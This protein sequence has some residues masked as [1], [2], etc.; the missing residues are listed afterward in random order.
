MNLFL[1]TDENTKEVIKEDT[2]E[3]TSIFNNFDDNDEYVT[4]YVHI[5][6]DN[7]NIEMIASKYN[8]DTDLIKEY[9]DINEIT[10]GSKLIIPQIINETI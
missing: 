10:L 1:E 5:V 2:K 8:V 6:R 4:Y 9:N 3:V 7:E